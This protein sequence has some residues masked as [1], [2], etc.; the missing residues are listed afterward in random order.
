M[1]EFVIAAT[2]DCPASAPVEAA[3][4]EAYEAADVAAAERWPNVSAWLPGG[5]VWLYAV[6]VIL[7]LFLWLFYPVVL[8]LICIILAL[9][10]LG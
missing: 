2:D 7:L 9:W 5:S 3:A 6:P 4:P 8:V 1:E 10:W